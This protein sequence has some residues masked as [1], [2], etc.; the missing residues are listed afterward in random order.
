MFTPFQLASKYIRYY[1]TASNGKGHGV[2]SPFVYRFITEILQDDRSFYLFEPI[3]QLRKK[4][5]RDHSA[6]FIEDFGAG[7]RVYNTRQKQ[8]S[9]IAGSS[10]K[11]KKIAQLLFRMVNDT[12]P[13]TVLELGTSFGITTAYLAA[14]NS[15]ASVITMEGS[16]AVAEMARKHFLDLG[17]Q[18]IR[19]VTGNIDDTL[20]KTL[21]SVDAVDFAFL[22]G[23]HRYEPTMR[24]FN[25]ILEKSHEN[26]VIVLDDIHWSEEM[27]AAWEKVKKHPSVT[28]TIDLFFIGIVFFRKEQHVPEHFI[29]RF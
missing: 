14:A 10:L 29:I 4:L 15:K 26:T 22:D 20:D 28:L 11:S 3:E 2:H 19:Q 21:E 7:S 25:K 13:S 24:Y 1:L 17:L 23:N 9:A 27:E 16:P 12:A 6:I 8:V 5:L 18:H